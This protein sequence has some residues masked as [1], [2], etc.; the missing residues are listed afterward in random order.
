M[1]KIIIVVGA[2][3]MAAGLG[4]GGYKLATRKKNTEKQEDA[5]KPAEAPAA[6]AEPEKPA[7]PAE[8]EKPAEEKPTE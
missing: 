6:P 3:L 7:E 8:P 1:K 5:A 2:I 4:F